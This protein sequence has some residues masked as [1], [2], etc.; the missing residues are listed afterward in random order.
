MCLGT[1]SSETFCS[2]CGSC[3]SWVHSTPD[4]KKWW[5]YFAF[6]SAR[7]TLIH[8]VFSLHRSFS[9]TIYKTTW[10]A[11]SFCTGL[12]RSLHPIRRSDPFVASGMKLISVPPPLCKFA[13]SKLWLIIAVLT[14]HVSLRSLC[15]CAE[16]GQRALSRWERFSFWW[17]FLPLVVHLSI[18][19]WEKGHKSTHTF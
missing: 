16:T 12:I 7:S 9:S 11:H 17:V 3:M 15:S 1:A 10:H 19:P 6:C 8:S 14:W 18:A 2:R 5:K 4:L 13:F